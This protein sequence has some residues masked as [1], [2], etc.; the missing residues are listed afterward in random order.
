MI[1]A[2]V[3]IIAP[4]RWDVA[5]RLINLVDTFYDQRVKLI[6]SAAAE[7]AQLYAAADGEE[8]EALAFQR[9][10][11]RLIEMRSEGWLAASSRRASVRR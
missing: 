3:P 7:P 5:R 11:S 8:E 4:E 9:T 6:V 10:V 2:G 1:I